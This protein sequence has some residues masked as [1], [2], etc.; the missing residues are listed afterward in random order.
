MI[1]R[2]IAV[3]IDGSP[4]SLASIEAARDLALSME[5]ELRGIFVEDDNLFRLAA[6]PCSSE[7]R[8][9]SSEA[10]P[11]EPSELEQAVRRQ[12]REAEEALIRAI[13]Q[14]VIRHSFTT[15]RGM[16][17]EAVVAASTES[18]LLVLGRS[19]RSPT[20]RRRLGS[21]AEKALREGKRPLLLMRHGFRTA[22]PLL[23][24]YDGSEGSRRALE[25]ALA[26]SAEGGLL[27]VLVL[28]GD[29][30]ESLHM[31]EALQAELSARGVEAEFHHLRPGDAK[32]LAQFIRMADSGLLVLSDEM[33]LE[34]E[35][36]LELV[37]ELDYPALL[38]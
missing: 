15:C 4:H 17:P 33:H 36:V 24:L 26:L 3:A 8:P 10:R 31:E 12:A 32:T 28:A 27:N 2:R 29:P 34:K 6:L 13:G 23:L 14:R 37:S 25:A 1:I 30:G 19:G 18:D 20:C 7:I 11:M 22:G 35:V 5:A 9:Y 38:V 21:T 16:V